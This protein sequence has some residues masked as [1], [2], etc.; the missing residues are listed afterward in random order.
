MLMA[1]DIVYLPNANKPFL[2]YKQ[3]LEQNLNS[4]RVN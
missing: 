3:L 2:E 1:S 4:S